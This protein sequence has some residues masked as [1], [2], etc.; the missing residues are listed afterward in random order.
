M[1][2]H[3][4]GIYWHPIFGVLRRHRSGHL[5]V[6][7]RRP[8]NGRVYRDVQVHRAIVDQL[9]LEQWHPFFG[10]QI[11]EG[12]VVHHQDFNPLHNCPPNLILM[13][14]TLHSKLHAMGRPRDGSRWARLH[15]RRT[16]RGTNRLVP[17]P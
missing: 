3:A 4:N 16:K 6:K 9:L 10:D 11:P 8:V 17:R 14:W 15:G 12:M 13:D 2:L 5:V 1:I 7:L